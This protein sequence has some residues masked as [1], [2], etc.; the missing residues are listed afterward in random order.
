MSLFKSSSKLTTAILASAL[1]ASLAAGL[2][3]RCEAFQAALPSRHVRRVRITPIDGNASPEL[4]RV[5]VGAKPGAVI[6]T[7]FLGLSHEWGTAQAMMGDSTKGVNTIYRQLIENLS[8][9]GSG[10]LLLR[11]GGNSSD[12]TP[13]PNSTTAQPFAELATALGT[14][15]SLGVNLGSD[16]VNLAVDQAK[17]YSS[18]MPS[19]SL[20]AIE[21]G[22]EPDAYSINGMRTSAYTYKD[23]L[24][25]FNKWRENVNPVLSPGTKLMGASWGAMK[26][27]SNLGSYESQEAEYLAAFSQHYYVASGEAAN[28]ED[29]LLTP[30][31]ATTGPR[32]V[33][34]AV[35]QTHKVGVPFRI[36][37]LNSLY[38]GGEAGISN[39]FQSA[40]WAVDTMFEYASV[41]VDGVN[42][43]TGNGG[44]YAA[45]SFDIQSAGAKK[46]YALASVNPL[47]YGLLFF[48]ASVGNHPRM[49]PVSLTT[50]AN[51]TAW[52]TDDSS[53]TPRLVLLNK[54][55][56]TTGN[57]GVSI[58]G[59]DHA[60]VYRLSAPSY[61]STT[62][63][64]F[65]GQTFDGSADGTIQGT[66][67]VESVDAESGVFQIPMPVTSASL[68]VFT[69]A[70]TPVLPIQRVHKIIAIP[71]LPSRIGN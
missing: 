8:A 16:N 36:G 28:P 3:T 41:G 21:I 71:A 55:E 22:N 34:A 69:N 46:S 54:D 5:A 10:P 51:L 27:L 32:A 61:Q 4:A 20:E 13:E 57:V 39:A 6:P 70:R 48:Q 66:Q 50:R 65:A 40:L 42:W 11:I 9:Y 45:F 29:I 2:P 1:L 26:T 31:A 7:G 18:Q 37:E 47:Y 44:A 17:A 19:G 58:R 25:D 56:S 35:A 38:H 14:H 49:L 62:G 52:A 15:F 63:V 23:Y 53:E 12:Q 24:A 33:T 30:A 67:A 64:T 59:Y 68:V 43:H 60:E